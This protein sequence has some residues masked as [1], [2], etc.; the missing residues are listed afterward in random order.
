MGRFIPLKKD[1]FLSL[2]ARLPLPGTSGW[3]ALTT[4]CFSFDEKYHRDV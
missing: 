2:L 4:E 3:S 1:R